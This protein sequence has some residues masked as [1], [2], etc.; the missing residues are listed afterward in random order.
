MIELYVSEHSV[1]ACT[2]VI[3]Q[4]LFQAGECLVIPYTPIDW[5]SVRFS[6]SAPSALSYE[7]AKRNMYALVAGNEDGKCKVFVADRIVLDIN[8]LEGEARQLTTKPDFYQLR[9]GLPSK[10]YKQFGF[11]Q[12]NAK[13]L[14]APDTKLSQLPT[15]Y[16]GLQKE[17]NDA[18]YGVLASL[19]RRQDDPCRD[20]MLTDF[21]SAYVN[22]DKS[23]LTKFQ[24]H[25][26]MESAAFHAVYERLEARIRKIQEQQS[27]KSLL[28]T[29]GTGAPVNEALVAL[30]SSFRTQ[31]DT[32]EESRACA[33]SA[34]SADISRWYAVEDIAHLVRKLGSRTVHSFWKDLLGCKSFHLYSVS[35]LGAVVSRVVSAGVQKKLSIYDILDVAD[36]AESEC[37]T[38]SFNEFSRKFFIK[39]GYPT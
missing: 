27:S 23:A 20:S 29:I 28:E 24:N 16:K 12:Q 19:I 30:F 39:I 15:C 6:A 10:L 36:Q 38:D 35:Q 1:I 11:V 22:A 21:I 18:F 26:L 17:Q 3:E 34:L 37:I 31:T 5:L 4:R 2:D 25:A 13:L 9:N 8:A 32:P 7:L 33:F 14:F